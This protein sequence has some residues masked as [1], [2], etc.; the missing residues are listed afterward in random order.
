MEAFLFD[1]PV[2][3]NDG[4]NKIEGGCPGSR[5]FLAAGFMPLIDSADKPKTSGF[6]CQDDF[7]VTG[8]DRR[9]NSADLRLG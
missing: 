7:A 2:T 9:R 1:D 5:G 3:F 6:V 4:E 8:A